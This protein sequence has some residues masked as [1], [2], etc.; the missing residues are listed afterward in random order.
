MVMCR[1][2]LQRM[3]EAVVPLDAPLGLLGRSLLFS[4]MAMAQGRGVT[5][6][7]INRTTRS[8]AAKRSPS[9]DLLGDIFSNMRA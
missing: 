9:P 6:P 5:V 2:T 7:D 8:P 3:P 4:V 1:D